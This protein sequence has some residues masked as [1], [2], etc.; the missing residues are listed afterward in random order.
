MEDT[1]SE[2]STLYA[3][4]LAKCERSPTYPEMEA[5][6]AHCV[7]CF[8]KMVLPGARSLQFVLDNARSHVACKGGII[9]AIRCVACIPA[10]TPVSLHS[11]C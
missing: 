7:E 4:R 9:C 11:R 3:T 1:A 10:G 2:N 6:G 8:E 5:A